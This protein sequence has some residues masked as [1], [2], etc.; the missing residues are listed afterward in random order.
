MEEYEEEVKKE[1]G[2]T[3]IALLALVFLIYIAMEHPGE[4]QA[5]AGGAVAKLNLDSA[6]ER[7]SPSDSIKEEQIKVYKDRVEIDQA[8]VIWSKF[9]NT[10]SMDPVLDTGSNGLEIKPKSSDEIQVGDVISYKSGDSIIIHRVVYIGT[11]SQAV[12]YAYTRG[13]NNQVRDLMPV[14]FE[15]VQGKL[16]GII[17]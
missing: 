7:V 3:I 5:V 8:D 10:N 11:D 4:T 9:T 1:G 16:I 2:G 17:Y 12:W 6:P 14:R 15:Q 13:D